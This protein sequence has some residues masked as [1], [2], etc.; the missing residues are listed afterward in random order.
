MHKYTETQGLR[1]KATGHAG[2]AGPSGVPYISPTGRRPWG[3][4]SQSRQ[5]LKATWPRRQLRTQVEAESPFNI[6]RGRCK[7]TE[8]QLP[9]ADGRGFPGDLRGRHPTRVPLPRPCQA[10]PVTAAPKVRPSSDWGPDVQASPTDSWRLG[11]EAGGQ[12]LRVQ[13]KTHPTATFKATGARGVQGPA[14]STVA[15]V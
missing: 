12:S 3:R 5:V 14:S 4:P 2:L 7:V 8:L 10:P 11:N 9:S 15:D 13:S 6:A 1:P